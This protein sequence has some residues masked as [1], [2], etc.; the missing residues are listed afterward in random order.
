M[1]RFLC[2]LLAS[3]AILT[4]TKADPPAYLDLNLAQTG[5]YAGDLWIYFSN[6][7][8]IAPPTFDVSYNGGTPVAFDTY[9]SG[10]VTITNNLSNAIQLSSVT[11]GQ[12]KVTTANSVAVYIAYGSQLG[13]LKTAPGFLPGADNYDKVWQN[14]EITRTGGTGDQGNLTNI[15]YFTAPL[16]IT[17]Y[18]G[19]AQLQ[20]KSFN[21]TTAQISST[22][23]SISPASKMTSNGTTVR[24]VGP[25]TYP[26]ATPP[27]QS[28][29]PY[30]QSV[31][32]SGVSNN[33]N[34][35]N[36]FNTNGSNGTNGYNYNF[37]Y[38]GTTSFATSNGTVTSLVINA[39][40][41]TAKKNNGNGTIT[42]G[43]T[44]SNANLTIDLTNP[45]VA[46]SII[47]GQQFAQNPSAVTW[48]SGWSTFNTFLN[49]PSND[50]TESGAFGTTQRMAIGEITSAILMGFLGNTTSVNGTPLND[51]PSN[52]WWTLN[53]MQALS[54]I[55]GNSQNYNQWANEIYLAS[56]NGAYSI[57]YSDR[58]GDGPL[59]NSVF[60]NGNN[61]TSWNVGIGDP[62][63]AV[64]EPGVVV[65]AGLAAGL[66]L[67]KRIARGRVRGL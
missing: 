15:N 38:N 51:M 36:A 54:Q 45:D 65:L 10:N 46:S 48:G 66:L 5:S 63:S 59:V 33:I 32:N 18:S 40:I 61:V 29:T 53:P 8:G 49:D 26:P 4:S 60:Y 27:Y 21:Q 37:T 44:F 24:F 28:F 30:L 47:Y 22:L 25:S 13:T 7:G 3:L 58:L 42:P 64:P 20:T 34:K 43:T 17:S 55:Q 57:P 67:L 39:D 62:V 6:G 35:S 1:K 16:S 11:S 14:F 2:S 56:S 41:L 31:N 19:A 9:T 52:Q 23:E 12:F 50:L